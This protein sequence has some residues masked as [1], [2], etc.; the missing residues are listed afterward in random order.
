MIIT[1]NSG[2]LIL[3]LHVWKGVGRG[4][5][6][7][8]PTPVLNIYILYILYICLYI[9]LHKYTNIITLSASRTII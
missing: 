5:K 7:I 8:D 1:I 9:F 4:I 6:F 2:A 3:T